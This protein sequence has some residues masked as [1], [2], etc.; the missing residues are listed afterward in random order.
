ELIA[1]FGFVEGQWNRRNASAALR[2][3]VACCFIEEEVLDRGEQERAEAASLGAHVLDIATLEQRREK[4]LC[5]I[6]RRIR[7]GAPAPDEG[8]ERIPVRFAER[9]QRGAGCLRVAAT[10]SCDNAPPGC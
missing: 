1:S 2:R 6:T 10:R 9:R 5:Q 3:P 7:I 8:V 4:R